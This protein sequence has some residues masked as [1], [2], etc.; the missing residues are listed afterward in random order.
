MTRPLSDDGPIN[1]ECFRA[2]VEEQLVPVR[3]QG[4]IVRPL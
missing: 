2:Y 1:G 4:D 3:K